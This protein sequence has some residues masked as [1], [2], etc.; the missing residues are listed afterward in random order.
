M[1]PSLKASETDRSS[2]LFCQHQNDLKSMLE[3]YAFHFKHGEQL[4][5][6]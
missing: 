4:G 1:E 3:T 6:S 2:S 5:L